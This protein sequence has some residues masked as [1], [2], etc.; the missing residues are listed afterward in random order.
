MFITWHLSTLN[1]FC[2]LV[3]HSL[4]LLRCLWSP[5]QP[6]LVTTNHS[7]FVTCKFYLPTHPISRSLIKILN[8]MR[9]RTEPWD[10]PLWSFCNHEHCPFHPFLCFLA[11]KLVFL[12]LNIQDSFC[13][14]RYNLYVFTSTIRPDSVEFEIS[15]PF[16][17]SYLLLCVHI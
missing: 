15:S 2:H 6:S 10:T 16:S 1:F 3:A 9:P 4:R 12:S 13:Y 7:N 11:P 17:P 8:H 14:V 5:S